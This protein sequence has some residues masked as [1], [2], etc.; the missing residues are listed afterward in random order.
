MNITIKITSICLRYKVK[1]RSF[2]LKICLRMRD[3]EIEREMVHKTPTLASVT[4]NSRTEKL[5]NLFSCT[6][7]MT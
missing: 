7:S 6:G 4:L 1:K 2:R 5:A 3:V